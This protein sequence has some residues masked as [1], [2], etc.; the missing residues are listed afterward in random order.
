MSE[1]R[2]SWTN[3]QRTA[4][5][6]IRKGIN[7]GLSATGALRQ[8]RE[9]GGSIRD[10]SWYSLY[11]ETF[12]Q[13][14]WRETVKELPMTYVVTERMF[15]ETDWDFREKY[16]MQMKVGGYSIELGRRVT[17]WVT[18]EGDKLYTKQEW[19]WYAQ[20]AVDNTLGSVPFEIDVVHEYAPLI[21]VR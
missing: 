2:L 4:F 16:I 3:S 15:Q 12:S 6:Y 11:R 14:G 18:V 21:R 7:D 20:E 5:S 10:S 8:Y 17:K 9:G 1:P 13:E 19:R